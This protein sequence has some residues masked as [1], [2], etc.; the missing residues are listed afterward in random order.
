MRLS[1]KALTALALLCACGEPPAALEVAGVRY[2]EAELLGLTAARREALAELT[3]FGVSVASASLDRLG[4]PLLV[5][6]RQR[7]L[8]DLL[9]ARSA[10]DSLNIGEEALRAHY[11]G[12]PALELTVR[13]LIVFSPRYEPEATRAEARAKALRALE[14]IVAGEDFPSVAS[15]VSEEPGAEGRQGLLEPGREGAW[16]KEFWQA[17]LAL[18]VGGIS[19]V[20]ETQYGFHVLRLEGRLEV[21]FDEAEGAVTLAVAQLLGVVAEDVPPLSAPDDLEVL[22]EGELAERVAD[23]A[24]SEDEV[25]ARWGGG[26]LTLG[27]LRDQLAALDRSVLDAW[28][29]PARPG[30]LAQGAELAVR[31]LVSAERALDAGYRVDPAR[32]AALQQEWAGRSG[33]WA[34]VLGFRIGQRTESIKEAALSALRATA[35]NA[36][37]AR[38]ELHERG[39]LIRRVY[40]LPYPAGDGGP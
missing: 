10:L 11:L 18:E 3:A 35:Q 24:A 19:P 33:R 5:R 20:V 40:R 38:A 17:A 21:P 2:G 7:Y 37:L 29:D 25:V 9:R 1:R 26:T 22:P 13:H 6:G 4:E 27:A 34:E 36:T 23:A 16:V 12:N 39:P 30:T 31:W 28:A 32:E 8:A 15:E 14:R